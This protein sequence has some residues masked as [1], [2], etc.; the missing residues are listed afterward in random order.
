[1]LDGVVKNIQQGFFSLY[2][3]AWVYN[4]YLLVIMLMK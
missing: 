4:R 3:G 2:V 1:L